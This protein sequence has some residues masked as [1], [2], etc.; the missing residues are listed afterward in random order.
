MAPLLVVISFAPFLRQGDG[1]C[2]SDIRFALDRDAA[3]Q[4]P[5]QGPGMGQADSL[6][7]PVLRAGPAEQVEYPL[8]VLRLD[9]AAVVGDADRHVGRTIPSGDPDPAGNAVTQVF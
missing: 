9:A 6:P 2:R 5:D 4:P 8:P 7:R 3:A 1:E